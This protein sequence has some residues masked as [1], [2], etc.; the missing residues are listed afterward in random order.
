M[1]K[2]FVKL[3]KSLNANSHPGEIAHACAFG[4]LLGFLPKSSILWYIFF[5]FALFLRINKGMYFLMIILGSLIA[6]LLDPAFDAIGY[7]V[8]TLP[9]LH[10]MFRTW[11]DTP[12]VAFTRFNNTIVA[13]SLVFSVVAYVPFYILSRLFVR[14]WRQTLQP[15]LAR[16]PVVKAFQQLPLVKTAISAYQKVEL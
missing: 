11:L 7:W 5:I 4:L 1:L 10:N 9:Q 14:L 3:L 8:L 13:G 2:Y 6:P 12:F 15:L 16:N